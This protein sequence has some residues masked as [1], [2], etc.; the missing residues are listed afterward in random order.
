MPDAQKQYLVAII[1]LLSATAIAGCGG[2][3]TPTAEPSR[4]RPDGIKASEPTASLPPTFY[5]DICPIMYGHC[6]ACHRPEGSGPF[7]LLSYKDVKGRSAQIVKVTK[8]R[9]MPPWLAIQEEYDFLGDC[10][11]TDRQINTIDRW[12]ASRSVEGNPSDAP[13]APNWREGWFLG[14]PDLVVQMPKPYRLA[15]GGTDV[16]RRFVFPVPL[17][18]ARYVRAVE[19]RPGSKRVI[20]HAIAYLDSTNFS[21]RLDGKD[22]QPGYVEM[23]GSPE[24]HSP[25]G[26][27]LS[28]LPGM[29]PYVDDP[30]MSWRLEPGTDL[31]VESHMLPSGK[32]EDVQISLG[33]YFT[34]RP[35]S[36]F[37]V[38]LLLHS[39]AID[40]PA[41]ATDFEVGDSYVLPVDA[42]LLGLHPHAHL[43]AREVEAWATLP[44]GTK[45]ILLTI[46]HWDFSW[47]NAYRFKNPVAL[48]AGTKL[49]MRIRFD[50]SEKN[51][52]NPHH[53]P[54]RVH[55][56]FHTYDEMAE[57]TVQVL[58]RS[59][60]QA[61]KLAADFQKR[62]LYA[63]IKGDEFRMSFESDNVQL[64]THLGRAL[65]VAG[66]EED[67]MEHL[68]KAVELQ[69]D[70]APAHYYLGIIHLRLND[71]AEEKSEL[72]A[73]I[74]ADPEF[75]LA[76][77]ELGL[78]HLEKGNLQTAKKYFIRSLDLHPQDAVA[79]NN[80][81]IVYFQQGEFEEAQKEIRESL[82]IDPNYGPARDNLRK[83]EQLREN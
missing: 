14:E 58:P 13:P 38:C 27:F 59:A 34:D 23:I 19:I 52:R 70:Y 48:P 1:I 10:H 45:K 57:M 33:I 21:R 25:D 61:R 77:S 7:S 39:E 68:K 6:A 17:K 40:I 78:W 74:K 43:L 35:P 60:A 47:Q 32:L 55:F 28:W 82:R 9:F 79:R 37:P 54:Q 64:Q 73:A 11:L 53:P 31:V 76:Q 62:E 2:S 29:I 46:P 8:S 75:Y 20:H 51:I 44:N 65:I 24:V 63:T 50:N 15:A 83:L 16:W 67:A 22:G 49:S 3:Q 41:G 56:G 69:P 12:V 36:K 71:S 81:G 18:A 5:H 4:R 26:H 72:E 30:E 66:R 42:E 80:L